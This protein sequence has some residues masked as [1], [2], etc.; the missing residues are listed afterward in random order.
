MRHRELNS[1]KVE[2]VEPQMVSDL[3]PQPQ[4]S[5]THNSP[6]CHFP[7]S[8]SPTFDLRAHV[9]MLGHSVAGCLGLHL[10]PRRCGG[11]L[12]KRGGRVKTWRRRW[13]LFD[14]DHRRLAYYTDHDERKLKGVIYFQAIEEVYYDH[15]RT[16]STSPR[17][18]LTFCVKTYERLFFLVAPSAEAMRIWMDVIV[19]ATDEHCH[20]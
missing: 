10:S 2:P 14:L 16:A 5:S 9:E 8:L 12:T 3:E 6:E 18:S 19:T 7:L 15:L 20:Y 4:N 17:P 11:F 13:F 1:H